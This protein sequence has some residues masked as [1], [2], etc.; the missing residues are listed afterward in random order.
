MLAM[1]V[2]CTVSSLGRDRGLGALPHRNIPLRD[3]LVVGGRHRG[4]G[5]AEFARKRAARGQSLTHIVDA[6][7]NL[8]AQRQVNAAGRAALS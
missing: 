1:R 6:R 7:R 3:Q 4:P 5:N 2:W 8:V